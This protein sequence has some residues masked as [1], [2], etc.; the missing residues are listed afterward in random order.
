MWRNDIASLIVTEDKV[1]ILLNQKYTM[2]G[3]LKR[4]HS[5]DYLSLLALFTSCVRQELEERNNNN[6]TMAEKAEDH[7]LG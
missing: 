4:L 6:G 1:T 3:L 2:Q 5:Y 7:E